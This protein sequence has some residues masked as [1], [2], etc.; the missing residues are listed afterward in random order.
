MKK[1]SFLLLCT[2][3]SVT[4]TAQTSPLISKSFKGSTIS[5][6][7]SETAGGNIV[8][9]GGNAE[10][11]AELYAVGTNSKSK[12]WTEA[13]IKEKLN[14]DYDVKIE[15][16][17]NKLVATA[18]SKK[19]IMNWTNALSISFKLY[20]PENVSTD[21]GT[22]GGNIELSNVNGNQDFATSGGNLV[23]AHVSGKID[24]TTS[25]GNISIKHS[26]D[27]IHLVTSGGNIEAK[28]CDGKLKLSTSGGNVVLDGLKGNIKAST[29]G[30]NVSGQTVEGE[31]S[32]S[33]SGGN[34]SLSAL[35]CSVDAATSGGDISVSVIKLS[36]YV[37]IS[38]SG[39]NVSLDIPQGSGVDLDLAGDRIK[40]DKM[41]NFSGKI[42]E[43]KVQG[44]LNGGGTVV[45]VKSD[46]GSIYL[47]LK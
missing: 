24:G 15:V 28:D 38:N 21:L 1:N 20:V 26:K 11:R 10:P 43:E 36:Q 23:I 6:V 45:T 29:S 39:G 30:G 27:D 12:K 8:V 37:R 18:K 9:T 47:G 41:N 25:G 31:L 3:I 17:N 46:G 19:K 34:V 14:N 7:L 44:K 16:E 35:S 22:S 33:T 40:T 4:A 2:M 5:S 42:E 32:A 13:E